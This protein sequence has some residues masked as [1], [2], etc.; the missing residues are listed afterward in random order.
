MD[1][2]RGGFSDGPTYSVNSLVDVNLERSRLR[3]D[4]SQGTW[5]TLN[6]RIA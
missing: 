3:A 4:F 1:V 6:V 5:I 2:S